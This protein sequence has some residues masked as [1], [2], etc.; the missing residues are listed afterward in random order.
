M[1]IFKTETS[2]RTRETVLA[3][4]DDPAQL[5]F[6]RDLF[7]TSGY[8]V[9]TACDG[10]E[11]LEVAKRESPDLILS[12]V[13]MPRM[14]GL[15]LCRAIR[16][17]DGLQTVPIVLVSA[18]WTD[19]DSAALGLHAGADDYLEVPFDPLRLIAKTARLLERKRVEDTVADTRERFR[20]L[21]QTASDVI[22]TID[23]EST[24]EFINPAAER[25]FGYRMEELIGSSLTVLM[26]P[27]L[28]VRHTTA[29]GRYIGTGDKT[30]PWTAVSVRGRRKDGTDFPLELSFS[31]FERNGRRYFTGIARDITER[32]RALEAQRESEAALK[33][34]QRLAHVGSWTWW[35]DSDLV[36][37]SD[38]MFHVAG[39]DPERGTP[40]FTDQ[41]ALYAA[42]GWEVVR[43]AIDRALVTG[44]AYEVEVAIGRPDGERRWIITRGAPVRNV[45]GRVVRFHGT[46]QDVTESRCAHARLQESEQRFRLMTTAI[47]DVFWMRTPGIGEILYISPGYET[48]WGRSC[49][50]VLADP[51]SFLA[52]IHADDRAR[53]STVMDEHQTSA[54]GCEYRV[55]QPNGSIRWVR[56][57]GYPIHDAQGRVQL[58]CGVTSDITELQHEREAL[59]VAQRLDA[60]GRLA[61]GVAHDFNNLLVAIIG[62]AE[63][64]LKNTREGDPLR[65]DLAEIQKAGHRAAALTRQLL[66]FSRKQFLRP[67]TIDLNGII[68]GMEPMLR[69]LIREDIEFLIALDPDV[70]CVRAD[71]SQL[72]QVVMN[73]VVNARDAMPRGGTLWIHTAARVQTSGDA[74]TRVAEFAVTDTGP[75]MDDETKARLFEPF[76]TTKPVGEG[77]GLGLSTVY[78][79]VQQSGGTI[80]VTTAV[81]GTTFTVALPQDTSGQPTAQPPPP[82]AARG[83]NE[84]VLVVEDEA[85]VRA[86]ATRVLAAAGY[87]V[88]SAAN[89]D[90]AILVAQQHEGEIDLLL[91]DLVMPQMGGR[92]LASH[93]SGAP[94][95]MAVLFMSGYDSLASGDTLSPDVA[96]IQK[97]FGLNDLMLAV[98]DELDRSERR[99]PRRRD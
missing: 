66:A 78:G 3:V 98:R 47:Q 9:L 13:S 73:L 75:G 28:R 62:Y 64:A 5:E 31:E 54:F 50:S 35:V 45:S 80:E 69:R 70:P 92:E 99:K 76:F 18:V 20:L 25:A 11:A 44:L 81:R 46:A 72:E 65:S 1:N 68:T 84:T 36:T 93:L 82:I 24:I 30:L 77:T 58:M 29:L 38:E 90:D 8:T 12:D 7:S 95:R 51:R 53:V 21:A 39:R 41:Q 48:V 37:W 71:P 19:A 87:Q 89:G 86:F 23:D 63:L 59:Q 94:P 96:V 22:I 85:G 61:G 49:E 17:T 97:P 27:E 52:A 10:A 55:V 26:P 79:I 67:Q 42:D 32:V 43:A 91:T 2:T 34:A 74:A 15:A 40:T 4:N 16:A 14:D 56:D 57:R 60:V 33:E 83:G 88:L 6:L